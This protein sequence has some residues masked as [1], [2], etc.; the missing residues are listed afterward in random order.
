MS[1]ANF[2]SLPDAVQVPNYA[3]DKL[4]PSIAHIGFGM[5]ARA[6]Q[7]FVTHQLHQMGQ[8]EDWGYIAIF[9][10]G[11]S[12]QKEAEFAA[13]DYLYSVM[14]RGQH[15]TQTSVCGALLQTM[16]VSSDGLEAV[17]AQLASAQT[18][19]I[20]L[21]VTEKAYCLTAQGQL[22]WQHPTIKADLLKPTQ[23]QSVIGAL[24]AALVKR[25]AQG[26]GGLTVMSCDNIPANGA[27]CGRALIAYAQ[28][29]D[30]TMADWIAQMVCFPSTMVDR[31]V[32][33]PSADSLSMVA[34]A[35]GRKDSQAV[36]CEPFLQWVIEDN[37]AQ[38][39][40]SWDSYSGV[41][42]VE[43]VA[44]Y[45]MMKLR[46]LNG[47]HSFL[48]YL[49]YL[50]GYEY[51]STTMSNPDYQQACK[52][53]M[54]TEQLPSLPPISD[55]NLHD[56]AQALIERFSN[57]EIQHRTKQ[58]AADGSQKLPQRLLESAAYHLEHERP[59]PCIALGIAAWIAYV[60]GVDL[61]G[62]T[63]NVEDPYAATFAQINQQASSDSDY[64]AQILAFDKV[65][66]VALAN[67]ATFQQA[68]G[69][70][71]QSLLKFGAREAVANLLRSE[72]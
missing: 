29:L 58:I 14:E 24:Y 31:I 25:R 52:K 60:R 21:T 37:F 62:K 22:D 70:A 72:Q 64:L 50:G 39:R 54:L 53:L 38:G 69:E 55:I 26:L 10:R 27:R 8:G 42:F 17:L 12:R 65:F 9:L 66:P 59:F 4:K 56:Y 16:G 28:R 48:A 41:Q 44:P 67:N 5:F 6:H 47:S 23:P 1:L 35:L 11:D 71:Y 51:I 34:Q 30:P 68:V 32:P 19:I 61:A 20:A 7:A 40:P 57:P 13:Q 3:R 49:G 36:V 45:E 43:D 2:Q 33:A 63:I 46:L 18:K 15:A